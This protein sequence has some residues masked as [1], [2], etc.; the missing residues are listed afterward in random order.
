MCVFNNAGKFVFFHCPVCIPEQPARILKTQYRKNEMK[1][2]DFPYGAAIPA[3][4]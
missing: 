3:G 4:L 2:H 1:I